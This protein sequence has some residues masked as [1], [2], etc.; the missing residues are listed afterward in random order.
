MSWIKRARFVIKTNTA[1]K[2]HLTWY[3]VRPL[4]S[5]K[6]PRSRHNTYKRKRSSGFFEMVGHWRMGVPR[7]SMYPRSLSN[8]IRLSGL[9]SISYSRCMFSDF[10]LYKKE[11]NIKWK[12]N[13]KRRTRTNTTGETSVSSVDMRQRPQIFAPVPVYKNACVLL[14]NLTTNNT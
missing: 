10:V 1:S 4:T 13:K 14:H 7:S 2:F 5:V 3:D 8:I 12:Q 9:S 11:N 6:P